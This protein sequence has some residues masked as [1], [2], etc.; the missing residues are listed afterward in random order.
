MEF[1]WPGET[2]VLKLWET[3]VEKGIGNLLKPYYE[4]WKNKKLKLAEIELK[5]YEMLE[6]A[7]IDNEVDQVKKQSLLSYKTDSETVGNQSLEQIKDLISE[8]L[9]SNLKNTI[10]EEINIARTALLAFQNIENEKDIDLPSE[11]L[12]EDWLYQ[13]RDYAS[14]VSNEQ[15]QSLWGNVL[16]GEFKKPGTYSLRT[17]EFLKTLTKKEAQIIEKFVRY[18]FLSTGIVY[19]V[20]LNQND[21]LFD[22][23]LFLSK[24]DLNLVDLVFLEELGIINDISGGGYSMT[25]KEVNHEN[26]IVHL[27][28]IDPTHRMALIN[29]EK[30]PEV[31]IRINFYAF[32]NLG[33]EIISLINYS[34]NK[35]YIEWVGSQIAKELKV[36]VYKKNVNQYEL[37]YEITNDEF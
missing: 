13:W 17:L 6:M 28:Q 29:N 19:L 32:T 14:K 2:V 10:R 5:R 8:V 20:S 34:T 7:K 36:L 22:Q 1:K 30:K 23:K 9:D 24:F 37:A 3:L 12:D 18:S 33:K 35:D 21:F 31:Y 11:N 25:F 4:P 16:A 26:S 15:V 27:F